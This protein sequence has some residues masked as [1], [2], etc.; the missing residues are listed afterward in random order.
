MHSIAKVNHKQEE[1]LSLEVREI[2]SYK[3]HWIVRKGN[4]IFFLIIG[5]I[6]LLTWFIQYPDIVTGSFRLVAINSPKLLVA[7]SEGK[8]ERLLVKNHELVK[9]GQPLCYLQS[10][11]DHA[12]VISFRKWINEIQTLA[13]DSI[14]H[15]AQCMPP[16]FTNPGELEQHYREFMVVFNEFN[17]IISSGYYQRKKSFL[18]KDL[19]FLEK[20]QQHTSD[21]EKFLTS[22]LEIQKEE[23]KAREL[24]AI[25]KV[26]APLEFNTD[27]SKLLQK[28]G[29]ISQIKSGYINHLLASHNKE[30]EV[31]ELEKA[32][33]DLR[34]KFFATI[35]ALK[36]QVDAWM[37]KHVL[38]S[39]EDGKVLFVSFL[40]ENQWL[41][42][43]QEL[44]FIQPDH[45]NYYGQLSV[46]QSGFGKISIGQPVMVMLDSYPA[47]QFGHL[48]GRIESISD[49]PNPKDSFLVRVSVSP[50]LRTSYQK[51]IFFRNMLSGKA[52]I[53]T[54]NR[55]LFERFLSQFRSL[56]QR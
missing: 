22:D 41:E 24:L 48:E 50:D 7:T 3:P 45:N 16:D 51:K 38:S 5:L 37:E 53:I 34:K 30:K 20:L 15:V 9:K 10:T 44:F 1:I 6:L 11:A 23:Y 35:V 25:D 46:S 32:I 14:L 18:D 42:A 43:N 36:S 27:K 40:Q 56:L 33:S 13:G 17:E 12:Q 19:D 8:L 2:I 29:M 39:P 31:L 47:T 55:T 28:E 26:I 54:D 4:F 49:I 21:Q 52:D